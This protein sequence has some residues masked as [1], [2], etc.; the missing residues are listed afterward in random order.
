MLYN[1]II[2]ALLLKSSIGDL[3]LEIL[4]RIFIGHNHKWVIIHEHHVV[5]KF[6]SL[7]PSHMLFTLQC[8][9]CGKMKTFSQI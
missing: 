5:S 7:I 2:S 9:T 1:D 6:D 3:M 8:E 4:H